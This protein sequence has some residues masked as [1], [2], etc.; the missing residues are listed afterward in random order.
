MDSEEKIRFSLRTHIVDVR[1]RAGRTA[2]R[3]TVDVRPL[4]VLSKRSA[5]RASSGST[6]VRL[7]Y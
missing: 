7:E 1:Y 5:S 2:H 6:R 4:G 3:D